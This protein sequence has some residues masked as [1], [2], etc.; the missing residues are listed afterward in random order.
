VVRLAEASAPATGGFTIFID[1]PT[2]NFGVTLA[3]HP[4]GGQS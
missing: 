3:P 4:S 2:I 1:H